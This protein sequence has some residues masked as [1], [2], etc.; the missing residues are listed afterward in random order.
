MNQIVIK[1]LG[2]FIGFFIT[3]FLINYINVKNRR[4][5]KFSIKTPSKESYTNSDSSY[6]ENTTSDDN[7]YEMIPYRANKYMCINTFFDIKKISNTEGRWYECELPFDEY[8]PENNTY[9]Y[10]TYD[11]NIN[12]KPNTIN[13]K[14]SFGAD[15]NT[16][17]LNGPKSFYFANNVNTNELNEFS[18]I[19]TLKVRD[20]TAK[21]NI[22]FEMT[23]N[24]ETTNDDSMKYT[25]SMIN[26]NIT[27][28]ENGNYDFIIIIGNTEYKGN[29]NN[30]DKS[31]IK[32]NDFL[33]LGFIYTD[34]EI[35][36][37]INKQ[38]YKYTT[39]NNFQIKLSST[40]FI[41]NKGGMINMEMYN[42]IYYKSVLPISEYLNCFKHN[43]HYLSGLH[44]VI[45]KQ[46]EKTV[47]SSSQLT[48][49]LNEFELRLQNYFNASSFNNTNN[50]D[51][52]TN[53]D[54]TAKDSSIEAIQPFDINSITTSKNTSSGMFSFLF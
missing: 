26:V 17:Q 24:T 48:D 27:I 34:K 50:N 37:L 21:N 6:S 46:D 30:I 2:F 54:N 22:L 47:D 41:I 33:V 51:N 38:M 20:I 3:L 16:I 18:I 52:N 44:T 11:K 7:N 36:F 8:N 14:G 40:P 45:E 25:F 29:I 49:K 35:T 4:I 1:V 13:N 43:Y 9:N 53:N 39:I 23:G 15:I 5:E 12:L 42:F 28:N 10:F 19:M 31:L 32:N